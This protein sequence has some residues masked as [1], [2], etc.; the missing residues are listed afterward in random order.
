[1]RREIIGFVI[2]LVASTSVS[3]VAGVTRVAAMAG[4][5]AGPTN[6]LVLGCVNAGQT[7]LFDC[8]F[9]EVNPPSSYSGGNAFYSNTFSTT[10]DVWTCVSFSNSLVSQCRP[11]AGTCAGNGS[12]CQVTFDTSLW[13]TYI[14]QFKFLTF[15]HLYSCTGSSCNGVLS[16]YTVVY[17]P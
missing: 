6:G 10:M 12:P 9:P 7:G 16:G 1:M 11:T 13:N 17:S 3:A 8:V 14:N 2:A 4:T 5:G 15:D